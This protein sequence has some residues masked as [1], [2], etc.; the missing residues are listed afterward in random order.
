MKADARAPAVR[1]RPGP[2]VA[3]PNV[4][5]RPDGP[6]AVPEWAPEH[7]PAPETVAALLAE[8]GAVPP[9]RKRTARILAIF[10]SAVLAAYAADTGPAGLLAESLAG[11]GRAV[12][13]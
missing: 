9:E 7:E 5:S 4:T 1:G 13:R 6:H 12:A 10:I 3:F 11:I 2:R 8:Y